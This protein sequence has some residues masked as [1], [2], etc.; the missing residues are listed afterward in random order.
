MKNKINNTKYSRMIL[1]KLNVVENLLV[2]FINRY[3]DGS[4]STGIKKDELLKIKKIIF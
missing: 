4:V 1:K 2:T 3:S